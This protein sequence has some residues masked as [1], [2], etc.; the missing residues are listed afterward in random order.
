MGFLKDIG[1]WLSGGKK[2]KADNIRQ[3]I[4]KLR[5]FN[6]RLMRQT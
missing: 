2:P 1:K 3:A 4:V 5:V 6:K